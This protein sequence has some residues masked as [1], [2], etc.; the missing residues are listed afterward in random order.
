MMRRLG[1]ELLLKSLQIVIAHVGDSPVV[2]VRVNPMQELIALVCYCLRSS[3]FIGRCRPNK[4]VNEM[5]ASL[6]NQCGHR[7][8]IQIIQAATDQRKSLTGKVHN[9]R[10]KIELRVQPRFYGV[11]VG[12]SDV[13]EMVCHK[14][15]HMTGDEL[16]RE[17]LVIAWSLQ[18]GQYVP[19]DNGCKNDGSGESQPIPRSS[20]KNGPRFWLLFCD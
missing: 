9:C 3:G 16:R 15:T 19:G 11:L 6:V 10:R 4:K 12:G 2:E 14:R 17:K 5:L 18:S 7:P 1:F 8:V 13:S 20:K